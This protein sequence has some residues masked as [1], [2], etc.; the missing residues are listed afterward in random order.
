M[1]LAWFESLPLGFKSLLMAPAHL[2][3]GQPDGNITQAP[4]SK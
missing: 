1:V 3:S 2:F 4:R